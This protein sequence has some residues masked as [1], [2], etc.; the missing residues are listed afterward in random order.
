[1]TETRGLWYILNDIEELNH[2]FS[3]VAA[4][5]KVTAEAERDSDISSIL[6]LCTDT[7]TEQS[8]K[9]YEKITECMSADREQRDAFEK[10][11]KKGKK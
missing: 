5:L 9:M 7:I 8:N 10:Q 2:R 4:M 6:W 3:G 1:M 11:L